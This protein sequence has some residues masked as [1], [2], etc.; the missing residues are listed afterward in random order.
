LRKNEENRSDKSSL[1]EVNTTVSI[2]IRGKEGISK[3][4]EK[5]QFDQ[6]QKYN[7]SEEI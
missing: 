6:L 5:L 3:T 1:R 7:Y 2:A 4:R